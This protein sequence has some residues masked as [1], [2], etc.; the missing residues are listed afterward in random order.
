MARSPPLVS[1]SGSSG[2]RQTEP[3]LHRRSTPCLQTKLAVP[4]SAKPVEGQ[5]QLAQFFHS[6]QGLDD[7]GIPPVAAFDRFAPYNA[8][9][10]KRHG[11]MV[12]AQGARGVYVEGGLKFDAAKIVAP[13]APVELSADLAARGAHLDSS[14]VLLYRMAEPSSGDAARGSAPIVLARLDGVTKELQGSLTATV[15]AGANFLSLA[16][17]SASLS[18]AGK[19]GITTTHLSSPST[20]QF[21]DLERGNL[22]MAVDEMLAIELKRAC[23]QIL[24]ANKNRLLAEVA[25]VVLASG[26]TALDVVGA[27]VSK[28]V[29]SAGAPEV[30][31]GAA[32]PDR[33]RVYSGDAGWAFKLAGAVAR[34]VSN[35][36]AGGVTGSSLTDFE[37]MDSGT[38]DAQLFKLHDSFKKDA[39]SLDPASIE[40]R[41]LAEAMSRLTI[42]R[43]A[44]SAKNKPY[45]TLRTEANMPE[46]GA[47][48]TGKTREA[49][50]AAITMTTTQWGGSVSGQGTVHAKPLGKGTVAGSFD[51]VSRVHHLRFRV[52]NASLTF[53]QDSHIRYTQTSLQAASAL[54][55]VHFGAGAVEESLRETLPGNAQRVVKAATH[56]KSSK[57]LKPSQPYLGTL[58]YWSASAYYG[59]AGTIQPQLS[60]ITFGASVRLAP[61]CAYAAQVEARDLGQSV[62][63]THWADEIPFDQWLVDALGLADDKD[64][65]TFLLKAPLPRDPEKQLPGVETLLVEACYR[66]KRTG[67]SFGTGD[68]P[69]L[70]GYFGFKDKKSF[71]EQRHP[72][73]AIRLR[74]RVGSAP[75]KT[76]RGTVGLGFSLK[77]SSPFSI[78]FGAGEVTDVGQETI[79]ELHT[80]FFG[81][82]AAS[83]AADEL[84][85][86]AVT[87]PPVALFNRN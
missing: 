12:M 77:K 51:S 27:V 72:L 11:T 42:Y 84:D 75:S 59:V 76:T 14:V 63:T 46:A 48:P 22:R 35:A 65:R 50:R 38:L 6:C 87:P 62:T 39:E 58:T 57:G 24:R 8:A 79:A 25:A 55:L 17:L 15:G 5:R 16:G 67:T 34:S 80:E 45:S 19:A 85:L 41:D 20:K 47:C 64:L 33:L 86:H 26:G 54:K 23:V 4:G 74:H 78:R 60:G 71:V 53:L 73:V 13:G 44:V 52:G 32:E 3:C 66:P 69:E 30:T 82:T 61:L 28:D 10:K 43:A 70:F 18:G 21:R 1:E 36:V 9:F 56:E 7:Y 2:I 49:S 68:A 40:F 81:A 31:D 83:G 29:N 37:R